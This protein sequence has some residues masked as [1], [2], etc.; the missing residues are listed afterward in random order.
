[1]RGSIAFTVPTVDFV[2]PA[3]LEQLV[4]RS[5]ATMFATGTVDGTMATDIA[6]G[7]LNPV[8]GSAS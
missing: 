2:S 1:M 5:I 8:N 6:R 4:K 3:A 7:D